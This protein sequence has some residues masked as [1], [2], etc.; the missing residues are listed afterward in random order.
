MAFLLDLTPYKENYKT[1]KIK[2]RLN[3]N[4]SLNKYIYSFFINEITRF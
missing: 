3:I 1:L 2:V 4:I